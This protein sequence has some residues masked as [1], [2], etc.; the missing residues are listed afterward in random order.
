VTVEGVLTVNR[1]LLDS[2]GRR[3]IVEDASGAIEVYLPSADGAFRTGEQVRVIGTVGRAWNAPRLKAEDVSVIGA[4]QPAVHVLHGKPSA[5]TEWSLVRVSGTIVDVR[6]SGDR[7]TADLDTTGG[8]VLLQG[9]AGS[10]I[11]STAL[12]EGRSATIT[13]IVKRP[14]PTAKDRRFA[15]VPRGTSDVAIGPASG[16]AAKGSSISHVSGANPVDNGEGDAAARAID[17]DLLDLSSNVGRVVRVG[18]LVTTVGKAD[19]ELDDGTAARSVVLEGTAAGLAARLRPGDA[20]NATGVPEARDE[21]VLVVSDPT[22][23]E[24]AG[25]LAPAAPIAGSAGA[26]A[27]SAD[28]GDG[29]PGSDGLDDGGPGPSAP[30]SAVPATSLTIGI[31]LL[32]MVGAMLGTTM[33]RRRHAQHRLEAR[34]SDRLTAIQGDAPDGHEP[35]LAVASADAGAPGVTAD[36]VRTGVSR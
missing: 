8:S 27:A 25:D 32:L 14:Y 10:G 5:A 30:G 11:P 16:A 7:W 3:T 26:G 29:G 36:R 19:F 12:I 33:I 20:L 28:A 9:L 17:I 35:V 13:G 4:R 21:P 2:S 1:T 31:S 18:G 34:I 6:R 22:A 23:I 24:L 15:V